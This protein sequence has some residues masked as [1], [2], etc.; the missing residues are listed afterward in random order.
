MP[1]ALIL[2]HATIKTPNQI[3]VFFKVG[4]AATRTFLLGNT[5]FTLHSSQNLR[6]S[7]FPFAETKLAS[8]CLVFGFLLSFDSQR[9]SGLFDA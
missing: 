1:A 7:I 2:A 6:L 4:A 8:H 3:W 9:R 5:I